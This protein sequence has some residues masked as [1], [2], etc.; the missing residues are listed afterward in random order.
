MSSKINVASVE[1]KNKSLVQF[2][3]CTDNII[4]YVC[5]KNVVKMLKQRLVYN[6]N[7]RL[8]DI[9][10]QMVHPLQYSFMLCRRV[11]QKGS[12]R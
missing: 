3:Q 4:Y 11:L 1:L 2:N 10:S 5:N 8:R 7:Y 12:N 6:S 9:E